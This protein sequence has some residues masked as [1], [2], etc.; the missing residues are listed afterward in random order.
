MKEE[1]IASEIRRK[2]WEEQQRIEREFRER[3]EKEALQKN[4]QSG[5]HGRNRKCHGMI[6]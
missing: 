2:Q 6:L 4:S 5:W 3:Q 1:R